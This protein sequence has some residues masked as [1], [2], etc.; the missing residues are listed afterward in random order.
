CN[1]TYRRPPQREAL[2]AAP[3]RGGCIPDS[4]LSENPFLASSAFPDD[5]LQKLLGRK[6][7]PAPRRPQFIAHNYGAVMAVSAEPGG[8]LILMKTLAFLKTTE[9]IFASSKF[10]T[11]Q[12]PKRHRAGR[13][14]TPRRRFVNQVLIKSP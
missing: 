6:G 9:P 4:V 10:N 13:V 3:A 8:T 5:I 1:L 2:R 12:R 14:V 11:S 7:P